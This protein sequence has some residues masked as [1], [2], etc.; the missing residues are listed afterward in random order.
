MINKRNTLVVI[1]L[2]LFIGYIGFQYRMFLGVLLLAMAAGYLLIITVAI[3][4]VTRFIKKTHWRWLSRGSLFVVLFFLPFADQII[5]RY[6]FDHLCETEGGL[7]VYQTVELGPEFYHEDG[8]P[9]FMD[10]KG[11]FDSSIF[12]GRY[13]FKKESLDRYVEIVVIE[14][15]IHSIID[16]TSGN[17]LGSFTQ[18]TYR[19]GW[20][21][22]YF[23]Y[24]RGG[25]GCNGYGY[26]TTYDG[27]IKFVLVPAEDK[28]NSQQ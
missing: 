6:Y 3:V 1:G 16:T 11:R 20:L 21:N 13:E 19:G 7:H 15:R 27:F 22:N 10:S 18:F 25:I 28:E 5:G 9:R 8:S 14:K 2:L 23:S 26:K 17:T 4:L 12:N 24:H